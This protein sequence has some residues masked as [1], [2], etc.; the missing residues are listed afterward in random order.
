MSFNYKLG[1][2]QMKQ[3]THHQKKDIKVYA[4]ERSHEYESINIYFTDKHLVG[5]NIEGRL[6]NYIIPTPVNRQLKYGLSNT[7]VYRCVYLQIRS[8]KQVHTCAFVTIV[9]LGFCTGCLRQM[10]IWM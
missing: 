2:G 5:W 7:H 6:R 4:V 10:L 3:N 8:I 1:H 9:L